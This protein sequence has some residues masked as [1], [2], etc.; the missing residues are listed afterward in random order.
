VVL[1]GKDKPTY[2]PYED[3]GDICV[4]VNAKDITLTGNKLTDKKYYWHTGYAETR[5]S[6]FTL[7]PDQIGVCHL[8]SLLRVR[9]GCCFEEYC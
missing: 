8:E 1:Q 9:V 6:L 7:E 5:Q 2:T 3:K 4:V